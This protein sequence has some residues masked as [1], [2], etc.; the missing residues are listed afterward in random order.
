[1]VERAGA[2]RTKGVT[3][4]RKSLIPLSVAAAA[5]LA[6]T[7]PA[8]ASPGTGTTQVVQLHL[9]QHCSQGSATFTWSGLKGVHQAQL[10]VVD[11]RTTPPIV[12]GTLPMKEGSSGTLTVKFNENNGHPYHAA[13][14]LSDSRGY[15]LWSRFDPASG[16][17]TA[18][19]TNP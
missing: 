10:T 13:G 1:M 5:L 2:T 3:M 12:V 15:T 19:C 17:D 16:D 6:S 8:A 18:A 9:S 11:D 14:V 4:G 7:L